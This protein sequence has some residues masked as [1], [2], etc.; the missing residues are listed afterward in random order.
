MLPADGNGSRVPV[1]SDVTT[2]ACQRMV[3][4]GSNLT[5]EDLTRDLVLSPLTRYIVTV[6][7][8]PV[9]SSRSASARATTP[10]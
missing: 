1:T 3:V 8:P 4:T 5:H 6:S 2:S 9:D 7:T 10:S